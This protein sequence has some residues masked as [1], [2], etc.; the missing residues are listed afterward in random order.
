MYVMLNPI[1]VEGVVSGHGLVNMV[2]F[3][4]K[5]STAWKSKGVI[6]LHFTK[7][8]TRILT[9]I[10]NLFGGSFIQSKE[11]TILE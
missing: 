10:I 4:G 5:R 8:F 6:L 7:N 2:R 9:Q 1:L 11:F 3:T